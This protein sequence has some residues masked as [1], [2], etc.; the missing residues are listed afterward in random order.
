MAVAV[1]LLRLKVGKAP[2]G[3]FLGDKFGG[4]EAEATVHPIVE[5]QPD[6]VLDSIPPGIDRN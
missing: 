3:F 1:E 5:F 6:A 2:K 4:A